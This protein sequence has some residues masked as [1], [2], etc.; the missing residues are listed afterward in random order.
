MRKLSE[1]II[2]QALMPQ[3]FITCWLSCGIR[4]NPCPARMCGWLLPF[5]GFVGDLCLLFLRL[6]DHHGGT[7]SL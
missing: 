2:Q 4:C 6:S 7:V 1:K 3:S 5:F